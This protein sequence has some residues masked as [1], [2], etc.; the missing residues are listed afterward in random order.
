M[1]KENSKQDFFVHRLVAQAF[2]PNPN[3]YKFVAHKDGDK[4]NNNAENLEWVE[5][6]GDEE[7]FD[8]VVF[9]PGEE[10]DEEVADYLQW[11]EEDGQPTKHIDMSDD[12][13]R[14]LTD[15]QKI[16]LIKAQFVHIKELQDELDHYYE[17]TD[18]ND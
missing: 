9:T 3:N 8:A 10:F 7:I 6:G 17:D 12:D 13:I 16:A 18:Y 4:T 5:S 14:L 15:D 2:V 1:K 11:L